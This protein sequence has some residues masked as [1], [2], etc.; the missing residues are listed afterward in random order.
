[1]EQPAELL[2]GGDIPGLLH[3]AIKSRQRI[4]MEIPRTE[5]GW[6][7]LFL[8]FE[9][10]P[11]GPWLI[12]DQVAGFDQALRFSR[13]Q[14]IAL[15]FFDRAGVPFNFSTEVRFSQPKE[16]WVE[17]PRMIYRVQRRAFFRVKASW[18]MEI[19]VRDLLHQEYKARVKD[20]SMGG[21]AFYKE[22]G[23]QWFKQLE[24]DVTLQDNALLFPLGEELLTIPIPSAEIRRIVDFP[25][26]AIQGALEFLQRPESS[27][28]Q[29]ERLIFE[30]QRLVIQK[31]K[32]G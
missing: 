3:S 20:Y 14:T 22:L 12:I 11:G 17:L 19:M 4:R 8:G 15:S 18:G 29:L 10:G 6:I 27:R 25:P 2:Q 9:T 7:T 23:E 30:Q 16:I 24:A 32:T 31:T 5:Y 26:H 1:M 28:S 13:N 21:V